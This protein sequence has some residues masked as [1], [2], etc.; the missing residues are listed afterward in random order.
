MN[1][2]FIVDP[3]EEA[4]YWEEIKDTKI[5][6]NVSV[7]EKNEINSPPSEGSYLKIVCISDTHDQL[8]EMLDIIP[9][10]DVLIHSG[11]F[12]CNGETSKIEE[13]NEALGKLPHKHK[14]IVAGNHELGFDDSED[15]SK[16][17][18]RSRGLGTP[19]GYKQI[20]NGI[21]LHDNEY[22]IDGVKF[23]GSS[24]HPLAGFPFSSLRE[25]LEPKWESIPTDTEILI[26][27]TPPLGYLDLF[28]GKERWGCRFLLREVEERIKP[29][30][31]VFGHVHACYGVMTNNVTTF[32][33]AAQCDVYNKLKNKPI[34]F[35]IKKN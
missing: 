6:K 34:V 17:E 18:E 16:R 20:T 1:T 4:K 8:Q 5:L 32:V 2:D 14:L 23:Y 15:L 25:H 9:D 21:Y 26:T 24:W 30:F 22:V 27:H 19:K 3:Y 28:H 12:T 10:G 35:Y 29:R 11:D 31:H 33:N 13:F 7:N